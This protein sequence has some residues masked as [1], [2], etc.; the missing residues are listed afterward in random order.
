M[1]AL[2]AAGVSAYA[3]AAPVSSLLPTGRLA[4]V[5]MPTVFYTG[6][7]SA[8]A[9]NVAQQLGGRLRDRPDITLELLAGAPPP[10]SGGVVVLLPAAGA[11]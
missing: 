7:H 8:A 4:P 5:S 3:T 6:G 10:G 9:A 2:T 11:A 1:A